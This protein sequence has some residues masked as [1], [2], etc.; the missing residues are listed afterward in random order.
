MV[1]SDS[2]KM[3]AV[4]NLK[5]LVTMVVCILYPKMQ[6]HCITLMNVYISSLK[7]FTKNEQKKDTNK[8]FY[9]MYQ[10]KK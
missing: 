10:V 9:R 2:L 8:Y 1:S 5:K 3:V 4:Q 7:Y 6:C